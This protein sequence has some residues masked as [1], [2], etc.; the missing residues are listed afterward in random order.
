MSD[1]EDLIEAV[2][3]RLERA[4]E[5]VPSLEAARQIAAGAPSQSLLRARA[6]YAIGLGEHR[7]RRRDKALAALV[8]AAEGYRKQAPDASEIAAVQDA[9]GRVLMAVG[10]VDAAVHHFAMALVSK[11]CSQDLLGMASTLVSLGRAQLQAGR[12]LEAVECFER[13]TDLAQR[14]G[15]DGAYVRTCALDSLGEAQVEL[16]RYEEAESSF[17]AALQVSRQG[18]HA[19]VAFFSHCSLVRLLARRGALAEAREALAAA[20][21]IEQDRNLRDLSGFT[22]LGEARILLAGGDSSAALDR[23]ERAVTSFRAT[24]QPDYEIPTRIALADTLA[25]AGRT[26]DAEKCLLDGLP[27]AR[28]EGLV[29]HVRS[30]GSALLRIGAPPAATGA[31]DGGVAITDGYLLREVLGSGGFGEVFR[32]FDPVRGLEVAYKRLRLSG[33]MDPALAARLLR[34]IRLEFEA[35]R[36]VRHPGV[37]HVYELGQRLDGD[38]YLIQQLIKGASLRERIAERPSPGSEEVSRQLGRVA[39][40]LA[41]L[42][43][44]GVVHRDLKPENVRLDENDQPVLIDFGIAHL[45][46]FEL[47]VHA[48]SLSGTLAYMAPEQA[49][50]RSVDGR[51]DLYALGVIAYEWLTG[52]LPVRWDEGAPIDQR[53]AAVRRDEP[54][55]LGRVRPEIPKDLI[56]L[57]HELLEKKPRHRPISAEEVAR[58]FDGLGQCR[59]DPDR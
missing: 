40:A 28:G 24:G 31:G 57:V 21:A 11:A 37:A 1:A 42:H 47:S 4:D 18:D 52:A 54:E 19:F 45:Q 53:I 15:A 46:D 33:A 17:R 29:R 14:S 5:V 6:L 25:N 35:A 34:S 41:A 49:A 50:G 2:I 12:T 9:L 26:K 10:R 48:G 3:A 59:T 32:A 36:R 44:G 38:A 58:R 55:P 7:L 20:R 39:W 8:D 27:I 16:E 30:I 56:Q 43:A 23:L 22:L 51:A 13:A